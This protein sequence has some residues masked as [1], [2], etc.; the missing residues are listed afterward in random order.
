MCVCV[1]APTDAHAVVHKVK[2]SFAVLTIAHPCP[3]A[4][5]WVL[6]PLGGSCSQRPVSTLRNGNTM[7]AYAGEC[8][9]K[10]GN[11]AGD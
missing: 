3:R 2:G 6:H 5:V 8:E 1:Y 10:L 11:E 4:V 7:L 9:G